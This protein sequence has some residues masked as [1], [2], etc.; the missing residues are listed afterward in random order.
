MKAIL[1]SLIV[2]SVSLGMTACN[3]VPRPIV[4]G[5]AGIEVLSG[6]SKF[7]NS[8]IGLLGIATEGDS[9]FQIPFENIGQV[10][11]NKGR[12]HFKQ[13]T[14]WNRSG[15]GVDRMS[16]PFCFASSRAASEAFLLKSITT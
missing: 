5:G 13:D 10:V 1:A 4:E 11:V 6:E 15:S 12:L 7:F 9:E 8:E 3:D 16:T 2:V 14:T